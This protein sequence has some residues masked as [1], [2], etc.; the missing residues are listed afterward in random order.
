[1]ATRHR[2]TAEQARLIAEQADAFL[3]KSKK[4][5]MNR[6]LPPNRL[7]PAQISEQ[8][9]VFLSKTMPSPQLTPAQIS[10]QADAFLNGNKIPPQ[11]L[12]PAQQMAATDR[13]RSQLEQQGWAA[14]NS[15]M[16]TPQ[17][18]AE[19]IS[20]YEAMEHARR[21]AEERAMRDEEEWHQEEMRLQ[22]MEDQRRQLREAAEEA[23]E[24]R[25]QEEWEAEQRVRA[26]VLEAKSDS[27]AGTADD[28]L[29]WSEEAA[30]VAAA[31]ARAAGT[32]S[33]AEVER[34][35]EVAAVA[36]AVAELLQ[37]DANKRCF[38]CEAALRAATPLLGP[39]PSTPPPP[40]PS[41]PPPPPADAA[42]EAIVCSDSK[43]D[44]V[45]AADGAL[46]PSLW[47]STSHGL[48]LCEAC[49]RV[50]MSLGTS[51]SRVRPHDASLAL[52]ELDVCFA[53]GNEAFGTYLAEEVGVPRH[54]WLALPLDARYTTPAA[55]LY[56]RRLQAFMTGD[57]ALPSIAD[58]APPPKKAPL[59][60]VVDVSLEVEV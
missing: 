12:T 19:A 48:L 30:N 42:L 37:R 28:S 35:A 58:L 3:S 11:R 4:E 27:G 21:Q 41:P 15:D 39:A 49:A 51:T 18:T 43:C 50:H 26:L 57:E 31:A 16:T 6:R 25:E 5:D 29:D 14:A 13:R 23:D 36:A 10:R 46:A 52:T 20:K 45:D 2:S 38:D 8:T 34:A 24:Q 55:A 1:M 22:E 7:T 60:E 17:H 53:G 54:V 44:D 59:R 47:C 9:D 56:P 40:L 33:A 32:P